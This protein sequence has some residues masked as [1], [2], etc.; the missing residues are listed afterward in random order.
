MLYTRYPIVA[1]ALGLAAFRPSARA[2]KGILHTMIHVATPFN[3]LRPV[4]RS[5]R[6]ACAKGQAT[7]SKGRGENFFL[8]GIIQCTTKIIKSN[9]HIWIIN[10]SLE[11]RLYLYTRYPI[12]ACALGRVRRA[13]KGILHTKTLRNLD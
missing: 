7:C 2:S 10:T 9:A 1:R 5:A 6:F 13:S 3:A 11:Y 4:G 12:V 8:L